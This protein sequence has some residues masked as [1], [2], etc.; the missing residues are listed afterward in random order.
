MD[1][2]VSLQ[3]ALGDVLEKVKGIRETAR[4]PTQ[5]AMGMVLSRNIT[6]ASNSPVFSLSHMDG[7]A[8]VA[9]AFN[10]RMKLK[11]SG[12]ATPETPVLRIQS[13]EAVR[14]STGS[15]IP[16]GA[17]AVIPAEDVGEERGWMLGEKRVQR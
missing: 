2:Y 16:D 17:D 4:V 8:V 10:R 3:A 11:I 5:N 7:F 12:E 15:R 13:G 14:V 1:K 9:S 6:S